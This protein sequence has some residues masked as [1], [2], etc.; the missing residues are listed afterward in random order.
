[1]YAEER[2]VYPG[3]LVG[4]SNLHMTSSCTADITKSQLAMSVARG[5]ACLMYDAHDKLMCAWWMQASDQSPLS[6]LC[7]RPNRGCNKTMSKKRMK[8]MLAY[9]HSV[10][11]HRQVTSWNL[12]KQCLTVAH[13]VALD[14]QDLYNGKNS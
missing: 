1:M 12:S 8:H 2:K 7:L 13:F 9:K 5:C 10:L 11:D 14:W 4:T 3:S 6:F